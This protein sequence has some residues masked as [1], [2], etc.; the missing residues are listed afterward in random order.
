MKAESRE[1][2]AGLSSISVIVL[3]KS[4]VPACLAAVHATKNPSELI[5]QPLDF[6]FKLSLSFFYTHNLPQHN[7]W[8]NY[9]TTTVLKYPDSLGN[10]VTRWPV[11]STTCTCG[12]DRQGGTQMLCI[13]PFHLI[14]YFGGSGGLRTL[15]RTQ[16]FLCLFVCFLNINIA[17]Y[18]CM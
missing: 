9:T 10:I 1:M 5:S 15:A 14:L 3:S 18:E 8:T 7:Q 11:G 12:D 4:R 17:S 13:I 6:P 2:V 16:A